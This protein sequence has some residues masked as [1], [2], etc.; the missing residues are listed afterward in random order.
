MDKIL[1]I[2]GG[3]WGTAFANY[4]AGIKNQPVKIWLREPEVITAIQSKQENPVFL[5]DLGHR[6]SSPDRSGSQ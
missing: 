6:A 4:L 5:R 1:M 3:S 2:G